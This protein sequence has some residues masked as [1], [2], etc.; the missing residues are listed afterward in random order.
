MQPTEGTPMEHLILVK[1]MDCTIGH[2]NTTSTQG[3][4]F[5]R[6]KAIADIP[7]THKYRVRQNE[8]TEAYVLN[9]RTEQKSQ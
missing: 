4:C 8:E 2:C 7:N 5:P 6:P 3:Y 1:R 9:E